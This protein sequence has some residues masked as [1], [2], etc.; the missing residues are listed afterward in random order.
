MILI[1]EVKIQMIYSHHFQEC[2]E[3]QWEEEALRADSHLVE[4]EI[5]ILLEVVPMEVASAVHTEEAS[6]VEASAAVTCMVDL[7]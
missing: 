4:G 5:K 7:I 6:V 2:Q 1:G 3:G